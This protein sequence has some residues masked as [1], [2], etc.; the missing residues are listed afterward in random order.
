MIKIKWSK[1]FFTILFLLLV[2]FIPFGKDI[3]TNKIIYG[4]DT[5]K[6]VYPFYSFLSASFKNG[7]LP[8]WTP[9]IYGGYPLSAEGQL[10]LFYPAN[11]VFVF[12]SQAKAM[13]FLTFL[14]VFLAGF[15]A[16][17][18]ARILGITRAGSL[19]AALI[20]MFSGTLFAHLQFTWML[21]GYVWLPLILVFT[22]LGIIKKKLVFFSLSGTILALQF[23]SGHP[24][25]PTISLIVFLIWTTFRLF[26]KEKLF[27]IKSLS[28][29]VLTLILLLSVRISELAYLI[30]E[31]VRSH[32]VSFEDAT[33]SSFSFFDFIT[34]L[35]P[36]FYLSNFHSFWTKAD[37]WHFHGYW[38][39][40]ETVGYVGILPFLL[41]LLS[42]FSK[43]K[44]KNSI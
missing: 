43:N 20:F 27:L 39:A 36:N 37:I 21:E 38:G 12:L 6:I 40:I 44:V 35:F 2:A 15:F 9:Y 17:I 33:N 3:L 30:P 8:L 41:S 31:S 26:P 23:F 32:G 24:N 25:N 34:F 1:D 18:F 5:P 4:F 13:I 10:G 7:E 29:A 28:F 14:H 42:I 19:I 22:E 11:L 16:F